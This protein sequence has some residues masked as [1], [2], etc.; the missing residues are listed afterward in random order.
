MRD[1]QDEMKGGRGR[2]REGENLHDGF[3]V[4]GARKSVHFEMGLGPWHDAALDEQLREGCA[5]VGLC[6]P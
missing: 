1:L 5:V 2:E 3:A 6:V 4:F